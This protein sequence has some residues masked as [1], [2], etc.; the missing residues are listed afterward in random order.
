MPLILLRVTSDARRVTSKI[1]SPARVARQNPRRAGKTTTKGRFDCYPNNPQG[2]YSRRRAPT[3]DR[4]EIE[5]SIERLEELRIG[6]PNRKRQRYERSQEVIENK[7]K[8]FSYSLQSQE[9][10]ENK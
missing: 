7:G 9:V 4:F 8:C 1:D 10:F 6:A 5:N 3:E 2:V